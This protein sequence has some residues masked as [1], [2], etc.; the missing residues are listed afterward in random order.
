MSCASW[1]SAA[2]PPLPGFLAL[3][4]RNICERFPSTPV[5]AETTAVQVE[6]EVSE[7]TGADKVVE[8]A[9]ATVGQGEQVYIVLGS[10]VL[11]VCASL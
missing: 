8:G 7:V 3:S 5:Q 2:P 1:V 11:S 10:S 6:T 4:L 9:T